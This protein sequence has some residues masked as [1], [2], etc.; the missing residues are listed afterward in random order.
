MMDNK[1]RT[2]KCPSCGGHGV[3][4]GYDAGPLDCRECNSGWLFIR[5]KGHLFLYPGG[6]GM[7]MWSAEAYND[8]EPFMSEPEEE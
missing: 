3:V 4:D 7:G 2:L 6:P 5:P 8:G 1:W